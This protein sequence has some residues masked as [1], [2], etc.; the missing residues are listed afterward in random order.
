MITRRGFMKGV[1]GSL[2]SLMLVG[3]EVLQVP[4]RGISLQELFARKEHDLYLV[5][6]RKCEELIRNSGRVAA[7]AEE[8]RNQR[9]LEAW[10]EKEC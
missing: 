8:A 9:I 7:R 3:A 4:G 1:S 5:L 10:S 6:S 2:A